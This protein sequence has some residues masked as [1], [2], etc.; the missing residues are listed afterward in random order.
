M[1]VLLKRNVE[2]KGIR[3][4]GNEPYPVNTMVYD[5]KT[6]AAWCIRKI[7]CWQN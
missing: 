4:K 6:D 2:E 1:Q 5:V 3:G 7:D